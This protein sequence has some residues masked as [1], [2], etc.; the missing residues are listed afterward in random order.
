MNKIR[1][2]FFLIFSLF[3]FTGTACKPKECF[4]K[5]SSENRDNRSPKVIRE[6]NAQYKKASKRHLKLQ[7]PETRKRIKQ[8]LKQQEKN[9]KAGQVF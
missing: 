7:T 2:S 4:S 9:Y 5:T 1:F 3:I 8:N 6:Q